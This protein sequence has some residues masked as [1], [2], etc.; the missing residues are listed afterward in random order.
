MYITYKWPSP[1]ERSVLSQTRTG[2]IGL[3]NSFLAAIHRVESDMQ[4][5]TAYGE[6]SAADGRL[7]GCPT[8]PS[9]RIARQKEC[10]ACWL[11][12][13]TYERAGWP[14]AYLETVNGSFSNSDR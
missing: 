4:T 6:K 14:L 12:R 13:V 8:K 5:S 7:R 2:K 1:A 10:S 11:V 9:S 3:I